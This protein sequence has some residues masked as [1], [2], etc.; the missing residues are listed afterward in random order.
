M[1]GE[2]IIVC[3]Q[4]VCANTEFDDLDEY[5]YS[6]RKLSGY[7]YNDRFMLACPAHKQFSMKVAL[8]VPNVREQ[9]SIVG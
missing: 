5:V 2:P 8:K 7:D 6:A 9:K 3:V 1:C 4:V